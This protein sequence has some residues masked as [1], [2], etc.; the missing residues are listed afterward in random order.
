MKN[1]G[2][3]LLLFCVVRSV[4]NVKLSCEFVISELSPNGNA[5]I[6]ALFSTELHYFTQHFATRRR[7]KLNQGLLP[8]HSFR[9]RSAESEYKRSFSRFLFVF[10]EQSWSDG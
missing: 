4:E 5:F 9:I 7:E 10:L 3:L 2:L 1:Q 6:P 8:F